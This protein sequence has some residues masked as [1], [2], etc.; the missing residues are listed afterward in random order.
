MRRANLTAASGSATRL[1]VARHRAHAGGE[2]QALRFDLVAHDGDGRP[3]RADEGD[4]PHLQRVHEGGIFRKEAVA[5]MDRFRTRVPRRLYDA[6]D[7][8]VA[9]GGWRRPDQYGLVRL[10]HMER[11]RIRLGIDRDRRNPHAARGANDATGD[12]APVRD[13]DLLEH[14]ARLRRLVRSFGGAARR[15]GHAASLVR[16]RKRHR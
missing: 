9:L 13:Q 4:L 3:G 5:R 8:E 11:I 2:G 16:S 15:R 10:A 7:A 14:G 1:V 12:L 6:R